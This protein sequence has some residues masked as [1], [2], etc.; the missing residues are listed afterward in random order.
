MS[1]LSDGEN[2]QQFGF[3]E[4]NE[5][6]GCTPPRSLSETTK[7]ELGIGNLDKAPSRITG[8]FTP[9]RNQLQFVMC[10]LSTVTV[11]SIQEAFRSLE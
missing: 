11:G 9:G 1:R 2:S 6:A 8:A 10:V 7:T 5:Y 3:T 4:I